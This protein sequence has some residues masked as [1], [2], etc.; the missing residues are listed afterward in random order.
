MCFLGKN[1]E[2]MD[3]KKE[4]ELIL[5]P[6][7]IDHLGIKMY[8][9]PVDVIS[10]FISNAW[11]A[12]AENVEILIDNE[13]IIICDDGTGMS[14]DQCQSCFLTVGRDRRIDNEKEVS[15]EKGR[16][17]LGRKGIGKFAGFGIAK[18]IEVDTTS[19]KTKENTVFKMDLKK[20]MEID[21][22]SGSK[23]PIDVVQYNRDSLKKGTTICL[24]GLNDFKL[25]KEK[26]MVEL[27]RRF[28][29]P[30]MA[31]DFVI[32]VNDENLPKNF[33]EEMEFVFPESLTEE[34]KSQFGNLKLDVNGWGIED[35]DGNEIKWRIGF[36]EETIKDE[37]LRGISIFAK[38][39]MA[40][41][42]FFFDLS[43]GISGQ[44]ALEY[45]TGQ[46]QMDFI[47]T[48]EN[49]LISTERQRINLQGEIGKKIRTWGIEKIKILSSIWKKRRS[50][51]R[52]AELDDKIS[53]FKERLDSLSSREKKTVET[54]LKKIAGFPR[55]GKER[56]KE[57]CNDV[58][59]SWEKGRLKDLILEISEEKDLDEQKFLDILMESGV[60]TA[61][62]ISESI[63]TK[64]VTIGEL[65]QRVDSKQ[66]ENKVRDFIY[67]H[68]W[69]IHPQ[70]ESF[71]KE[72]SVKHIIEAAGA[73]HLDGEFFNGRVDLV[74]ASGPSM[75]VVEFMRPG[76]E[77]DCDHLDRVNYYVADIRS[78]LSA[79]TAIGV[80]NLHT[81]YVIADNKKQSS[82][83]STR[84]AQLERENILVMTWGGLIDSALKQWED[85]LELLKERFPDDKRIKDL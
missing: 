38:G 51:K 54:V 34:E 9:K 80:K 50:E 74:L 63:K 11:D 4:L 65:K 66:L 36:F 19:N 45:M 40:Q 71:K 24:S 35:I 31:S 15:E 76:L 2:K 23:K 1:E 55:L 73:K 69:I 81:A 72:I 13:T 53:G 7:V 58:L 32:K 16:P 56:Y 44:N 37:E 5:Q 62:N 30:Q 33:C 27:S 18:N 84:I 42:P 78:S 43:G 61:I 67:D 10:E 68:P 47:D 14:F 85:Y 59:T 83:M 20:I 70:W 39:K 17:V 21:A 49:N 8:Q 12:D 64:I 60:L 79:Q 3:S 6:R 46:M 29:L 41:K 28:L 75:L 57:W 22:R 25:E 52:L 77:I 48:G 82:L 26:F